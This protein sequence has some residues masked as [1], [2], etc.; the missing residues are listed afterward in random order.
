MD[1]TST[2]ATL[3]SEFVVAT[4][5]IVVVVTIVFVLWACGFMTEQE[6]S[7]CMRTTCDSVCIAVLTSI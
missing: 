1:A 2:A 5:L 7:S 3:M 6:A 4:G